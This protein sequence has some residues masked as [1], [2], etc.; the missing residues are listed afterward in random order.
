[1]LRQLSDL[2]E[3]R[4]GSPT[5]RR[6]A[7]RTLRRL[8]AAA[9]GVEALTPARDVGA[10]PRSGVPLTDGPTSRRSS[11]SGGSLVGSGRMTPQPPVAPPTTTFSSLVASVLLFCVAVALRFATVVAVVLEL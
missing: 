2:V 10:R 4:L 9:L 1:M 8:G 7:D 5:A 11:L 6:R 3:G